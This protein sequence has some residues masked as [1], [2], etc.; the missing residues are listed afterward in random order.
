MGFQLPEKLK[1]LEYYEPVTEAYRIRLDAN[2]S[3]H[4][5][6][7]PLQEELLGKIRELDLNRYPDPYA[8]ELRR[9]AGAWYGLPSSCLTPGCGSDELIGLILSNLL[10][11]GDRCVVAMPDFSMYAFYAGLAG[12]EAVD[13]GKEP[14]GEECAP[15]PYA[16][17]AD[18]L[19]RTVRE[20]GARMLIFSNPCNPTSLLLSGGEMER[21][22]RELPDVLLVAD[23][24]YME[25]AD[26][27]ASLLDR[28][29]GCDHLIVL[30]T[31]SKAFGM[32]GIRLGFAAACEELTRVLMAVKSPYN[33][34]SM[35]QAAGCVL[36]SHPEYL[37]ECI[38]SS[39]EARDEL[40][41]QVCALKEETGGT[42]PAQDARRT[43]GAGPAQDALR[44]GTSGAGPGQQI[45]ILR[46]LRPQTNFV[47]LHTTDDAA[48][49]RAL[50]SRGIS[51]RKFAFGLRITAGSPQEI[52]E[53]A[54]A[55]R[56]ILTDRNIGKAG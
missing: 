53:T 55:L 46:V 34:N 6:P 3:W 49:H 33:V 28:V 25:F 48:I 27:G 4:G 32:A 52:R 5:L 50:Q 21:L 11:P 43:G 36:F 9:L 39:R 8:T 41:R 12:V 10:G 26:E 42:D 35:T 16:L 40:Y 54:A 44:S 2:E 37:Q 14:D 51:V 19:I 22:V 20:S 18:R 56:Q 17:T 29:P 7:A 30:K 15:E 24:A 38:R 31:C 45:R 1:D 47:F 23:E 13:A